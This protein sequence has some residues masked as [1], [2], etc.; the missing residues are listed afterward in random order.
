MIRFALSRPALLLGIFGAAVAQI[1]VRL[2]CFLHLD[3]SSEARWNLLAIVF[4]VLFLIL[5]VGGRSGLC[6][7]WITA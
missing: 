1:L 7:T 4:T 5:F 2:N 6:P 3:T